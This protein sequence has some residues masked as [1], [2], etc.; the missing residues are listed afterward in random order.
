[1]D[2]WGQQQQQQK[3]TDVPEEA[4]GDVVQYSLEV[5]TSAARRDTSPLVERRKEKVGDL[6]GQATGE[7]ERE[8]LY[9]V[10][11]I[12]TRTVT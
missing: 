4:W 12:W 9:I 5:A 3:Y 6:L 2:V 11:D 8:D 1:M 7:G 10:C